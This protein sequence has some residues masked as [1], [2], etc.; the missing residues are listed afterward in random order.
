M[1]PVA[2]HVPVRGAVPRACGA[3]SDVSFVPV[4]SRGVPR[5][6]RP[7]HTIFR[8]VCEREQG[9]RTRLRERTG[10]ASRRHFVTASSP[11]T[12]ARAALYTGKSA[13]NR[14]WKPLGQVSLV[15]QRVVFAVTGRHLQQTGVFDNSTALGDRAPT[16]GHMLQKLGYRTAYCGKFHLDDT[17]FSKAEHDVQRQAAINTSVCF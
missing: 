7:Q 9:W 6:V 2:D 10:M 16:I 3:P 15:S 17:L 13:A 11:C 1:G 4:C 8:L 14:A 5:G 12:P